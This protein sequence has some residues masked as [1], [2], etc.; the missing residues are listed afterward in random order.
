MK[1]IFALALALMLVMS[2]GAAAFA[3]EPKAG[4]STITGTDSING[5]TSF[6][7]WGKNLA[8]N[9]KTSVISV[10]VEYGAMKFNYV[11]ANSAAIW[12]PA[13]HTYSDAPS[14]ATWQVESNSNHIK[15]TNHSNVEV[16]VDITATVDEDY[17][18]ITGISLKYGESDYTPTMLSAGE[19]DNFDGAANIVVDVMP[20]GSISGVD[21]YTVIGSITVSVTESI[22]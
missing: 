16:N 1:K 9:E 10:D 12:N 20:V 15:I 5:N 8:S 14:E 4:T 6:N 7:V 11:E 18:S 21:N 17:N 13:D 22:S 2:M 3:A 19:K